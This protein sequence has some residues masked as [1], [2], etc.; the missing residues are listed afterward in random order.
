MVDIGATEGEL[1]GFFLVRDSNGKPRFD[2]IHNIAP[3]FWAVLTTQEQ[4]VILQERENGR[5]SQSSNT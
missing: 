3:E 1:T 2:D 4:D 5:N